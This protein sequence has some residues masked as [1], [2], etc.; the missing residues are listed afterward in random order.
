MQVSL[1]KWGLIAAQLMLGLLAF[2]AVAFAPPAYGRMLL[3]PLDGVPVSRVTVTGLHATP[4]IA[5]PLPGSMVVEGDRGLLSGLW[6]Q[7]ILV[8]AAPG[9]LCG[10]AVS[11]ARE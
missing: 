9:A 7:G 1:R 4:L 11:E 10:G 6:S 3:V 5:G 8:V 2:L